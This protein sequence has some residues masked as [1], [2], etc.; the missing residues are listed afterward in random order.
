MTTVDDGRVGK[1]LVTPSR[2][3]PPLEVEPVRRAVMVQRWAEVVFLHWR[4]EPEVV[5][6]LLPPGV[7]VDVHDE[8][9]WIGLVPFH[10]QRLGI[11]HLGPLPFVHTFPEIN[12]RT[13]VHSGSRRGVWFF[14][15][16]IDRLLPTLVARLSYHLPYCFGRGHHARVGDLVTSHIERRWPRTPSSAG[17]EIAVR[18]GGRVQPHDA[19]AHFLT[20]RWGLIANPGRG[21]L[22]YAPVDHPPWPL[23]RAELEHLD[24]RLIIAAGLPAPVG[25]PDVMWSP[26]VDVRIGRPRRITPT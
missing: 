13:Y 7:I 12:V 22:R 4:Y 18:T 24:D 19:Q 1:R 6:R 17:T 16:D 14:S 23:H 3:L 5:Q 11:P 2:T 15:L 10:M 20:S 26:G 9:A 8:S 21:R 25:R